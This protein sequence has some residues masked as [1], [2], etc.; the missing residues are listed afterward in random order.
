MTLQDPN[1]DNE[2]PDFRTWADDPSNAEAAD[3][4][5]AHFVAEEGVE[6]VGDLIASRGPQHQWAAERWVGKL[7]E[8]FKAWWARAGRG[9]ARRRACRSVIGRRRRRRR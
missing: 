1:P 4:L 6:L 8:R 2:A 7:A 9:S 3:E 5:V